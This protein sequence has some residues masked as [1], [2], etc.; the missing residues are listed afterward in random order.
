[1]E[2]EI[3]CVDVPGKASTSAAEVFMTLNFC[4]TLVEQVTILISQEELGA[5]ELF[6]YDECS[7]I[8]SLCNSVLFVPDTIRSIKPLDVRTQGGSSKSI[9]QKG[10]AF[11]FGL[12]YYC[13]GQFI[14]IVCAFDMERNPRVTVTI[15][16][17]SDRQK[18]GYDLFL[19]DYNVT[20]KPRYVGKLMIGSFRPLIDVLSIPASDF[21]H[22][23]KQSLATRKVSAKAKAVANL[24]SLA[25]TERKVLKVRR[26]QHRLGYQSDEHAAISLSKGFIINTRG[27]ISAADFKY[28]TEIA[29]HDI[30]MQKGKAKFDRKMVSFDPVP[31]LGAGEIALEIDIGFNG[32]HAYLVGISLPMNY[33]I[34]AYLGKKQKNYRTAQHLYNAVTQI[35]NQFL[36]KGYKVKY[37][38]YDS[39]RS[40]DEYSKNVP[41]EFGSFRDTLLNKFGIICKQLPPGVHAKHVE[42]RIQVWKSKIRSCNFRLLYAIPDSIVYHL[43]IAAMNWC[44]LDPTEGNANMTPP[45]CLILGESVNA[46]FM[47]RS[48]FGEIVMVSVDS[49]P[50]HNSTTKARKREC[51]YLYPKSNTMNSHEVLVVDS[52]DSSRPIILKVPLKASDVLPYV[53]LSIVARINQQAV[54]EVGKMNKKKLMS[55]DDMND[56]VEA[57]GFS[58]DLILDTP[59][60]LLQRDSR[61]VSIQP[62]SSSSVSTAHLTKCIRSDLDEEKYSMLSSMAIDSTFLVESVE[63]NTIVDSFLSAYFDDYH[64]DDYSFCFATSKEVSYNKATKV[65]KPGVA[66]SAMKDEFAGLVHKWHPIHRN[67]LTPAQRQGILRGHALVKEKPDLYKGRFVAN[68]KTQDYSEYDIYREV[69]APTAMLSSLF[70]VVS[71]AAAK[72]KAVAQFDVKQAF[73]QTPMK[74]GQKPI[75]VRIDDTMVTIIRQISPELDKL[76]GEYVQSDGSVIVELDY[77]LYGTIEAG[78]MWYDYFK[79]ILINLGYIVCP[80]DDCTFNRFDDKGTITA[81]IV[82]HVD[83]GFITADSEGMLDEF[84]LSLEVV[85]G[86]L[87]IQRGK[88]I[89]HLGMQLD[90]RERGKCYVTIEKLIRSILNDWNVEKFR[91]TPARPDLFD[92]DADS[93][94]LD[95]VMSKKLH[96][97]IAQLLYFVSKVR[98]DALLPVIYLTSKVRAL[99]ENHLSIFLDVLYYLNGTVNLGLVLGASADGKIRLLAYADSSFAIYPDAKGQGGMFISYGCGSI[100]SRSMKLPVAASTAETELYQLSNTVSSASREL[101][102]AK[103]QKYIPESEPGVLLEDN[104]SAIHMANKG[105]SVSHRT[106]HIKVKYFFV[107]E[108]LDNGDFV[109]VHCPTKDMVADILTKPLQGELFRELRDLILGYTALSY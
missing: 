72:G 84:F 26:W 16:Y 77:A 5:S 107:K 69:S 18:I 106:R 38:L 99:T 74:P 78:R 104:M 36:E 66:S 55:K 98:P 63:G 65:F 51:I 27:D 34:C 30:P 24:K 19:K 82:L 87:S 67:S 95:V 88:V 53:P 83:D 17:N 25:K 29:G 108:F 89:N 59:I 79:S 44:N 109:L 10:E 11:V 100:L 43:G 21:L 56:L 32:S 64:D 40:L 20:L 75:H 94:L 15:V 37:L 58:D 92:D 31:A 85:L 71:F 54:S 45:M 33:G 48:S 49:G 81:T 41:L 70:G 7:N 61:T 103:Y 2:D 13:V 52:I 3:C 8:T 4:F 80:M 105:K 91:N 39:E 86:K 23:D 101:E 42:R 57:T 12:S 93:P 28:A 96:R 50:M 60:E 90:F 76:Y 6:A 62:L 35:H 102:F 97:G 46:E 9:S 22:L 1:M 73:T 68:G 14:N 47:C